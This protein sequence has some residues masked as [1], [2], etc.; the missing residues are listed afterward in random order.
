MLEA[1]MKLNEI[2]PVYHNHNRDLLLE[3]DIEENGCG[4]DKE[5]LRKVVT[6]TEADFTEEYTGDELMEMLR[7]L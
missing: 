3:A 7:A 1:T 4:I 5:V 2:K 6:M